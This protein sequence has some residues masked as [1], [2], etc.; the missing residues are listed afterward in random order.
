MAIAKDHIID[1]K[2]KQ[3][4]TYVGLLD[5]AHKKGLSGFHTQIIQCPSDANGQTTIVH[6]RAVFNGGEFAYDGIGDANA[7]NVNRM[8]VPH[9]IRMAETRAKGRAL[10]DAL[11]VSMT[12]LEELDDYSKSAGNVE[13]PPTKT[14]SKVSDFDHAAGQKRL[15]AV[16][17]DIAKA[18]GLT[19]AEISDAIKQVIKDRYKV[20]SS[21]DLTG[22][23]IWALAS[24]I[25][26]SPEIITR[27]ANDNIPEFQ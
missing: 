17:G 12:M 24:D 16:A 25:E 14:V 18:D 20:D 2:G 11:N 6:A 7:T 27:I 21:K 3:F 19:A 26:S 8:I 23:Q 22:E 4:V 10:R 9:C 13:L 1:L 15:R 5:A